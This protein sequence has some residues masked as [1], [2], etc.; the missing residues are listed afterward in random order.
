MMAIDATAYATYRPIMAVANILCST[1]PPI[2]PPVSTKD[3][4]VTT[5]KTIGAAQIANLFQA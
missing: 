4:A 1:M 2:P 5:V 3:R